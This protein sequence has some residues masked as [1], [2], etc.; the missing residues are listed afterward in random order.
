MEDKVAFAG[1]GFLIVEK[2]QM[3][4]VHTTML[5]SRTATL[6]AVCSM[7]TTWPTVVV[8][9]K[10]VLTISKGFSSRLSIIDKSKYACYAENK[11]YWPKNF[12][13]DNLC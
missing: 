10:T 7:L 11:V 6:I 12:N 1:K 4:Y 13:A 2:T 8:I 5:G 9:P 3:K